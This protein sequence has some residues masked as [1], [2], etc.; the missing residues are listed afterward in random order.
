MDVVVRGVKSLDDWFQQQ[1]NG[2]GCRPETIAYI[3]GVLKEQSHHKELRERSII[4]AYQDA[5]ARRDFAAYQQLG[6]WILWVDVVL[7]ASIKD[8]RQ[9]FETIGRLS[10]YACYRML[11]NKWDLYE[12]L[13]DRLP[14]I[15]K[16][17][18]DRLV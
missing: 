4:L 18:R 6:D 8:N 1:L 16:H 10:Y 5:I 2:L 11:Y 13:A 15:A 7:P 12:E 17:V 9:L 3:V 14:V